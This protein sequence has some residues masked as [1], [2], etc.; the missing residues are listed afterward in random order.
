MNI[1][2]TCINNFQPYILLNIK[3][4]I[5]LGHTQIYVITNFEFFELFNEY[6]SKITLI[7]IEELTES[8]DFIKKTKLNSNFRN[9]FWV[10]TSAR[11]FYIQA[12]M[13]K[14]NV[15]NIIHLENDVLIYYNCDQLNNKINKNYIYLPFDTF[16][17]CISL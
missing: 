11:F 12:F 2:L 6:I 8:Y 1:V 14:Y 4:L 17:N 15:E 9:G 3:Q 13:K 7:S 10:L 16:K 5:Y